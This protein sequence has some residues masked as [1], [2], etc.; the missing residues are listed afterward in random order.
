MNVI[1]L[2]ISQ[3]LNANCTATIFILTSSCYSNHLCIFKK[4]YHCISTILY[5][6]GEGKREQNIAHNYKRRN[7]C[8]NQGRLGT[9]G[10]LVFGYAALECV[11]KV[12]ICVLLHNNIASYVY[13]RQNM[14]SK[15][16]RL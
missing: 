8:F 13:L 4:Q 2:Y 12:P 15:L 3:I 1:Y 7:C 9:T 10:S 5:S 14:H 16:L 6:E 11:Y